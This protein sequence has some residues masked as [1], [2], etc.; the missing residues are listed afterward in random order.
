MPGTTLRDNF[1]LSATRAPASLAAHEQMEPETSADTLPLGFLKASWIRHNRSQDNE[2]VPPSLFWRLE[3]L[4]AEG[5][6]VMTA[7]VEEGSRESG[8]DRE[9]ARQMQT[10]H[11]PSTQG[12]EATDSALP[13]FK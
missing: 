10:G 13:G 1:L 11:F 7:C 2:T 9:S 6:K 4:R 3:T 8:G 5:Q 12:A